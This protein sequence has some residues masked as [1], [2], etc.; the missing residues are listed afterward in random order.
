MSLINELREK[1]NNVEINRQ[2]VIAEI[3]AYFDEHL[4][5]DKLENYLRKHIGEYEV[6]KRKIHTKVEFWEWHD[7]CSDTH[8]YCCG[9]YWHNPEDSRNYVSRTYKDIELIDVQEEICIYLRAKLIRRMEELGFN[10]VKEE[11]QKSRF[12]YFNTLLYFGW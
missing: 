12:G 4:D 6:A 3:K 2:E 8:F 5:S 11:R 9:K 1:S 7:G 10:L